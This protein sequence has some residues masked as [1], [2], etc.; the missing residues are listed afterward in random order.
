MDERLITQSLQE[1]ARKDIPEDMSLIP[2]VT[3]KVARLS[4]TA[5]R[6]RISWVA[7]AVLGMLAVSVVAYAATQFLQAQQLDP[8]LEGASE[9]DLV[10][11][12]N[13]EEHIEDVVV[14]LDYAYADANRISLGY[15]LS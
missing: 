5:A 11:V 1:K 7:A 13:M 14:T 12:L 6:S 4:R 10:T 2:E 3:E 15:H 9:A 8:G